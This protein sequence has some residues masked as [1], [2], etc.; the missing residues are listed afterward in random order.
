M[1][2]LLLL[3]CAGTY[4]RDG[5]GIFACVTAGPTPDGAATPSQCL[6]GPTVDCNDGD[7][8]VFPGARPSCDDKLDHDC[9][10]MPDYLLA[11]I[12]CDGDGVSHDA[13]GQGYTP[14]VDDCDD[15]NRARTPG[16]NEWCDDGFD[17]DCDNVTDEPVCEVM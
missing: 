13:D 14:G 9:D 15:F 7:P 2:L 6:N 4:D 8:S 12:D 11:G 3:G 5:D 16:A 10:G 1:L 17:N